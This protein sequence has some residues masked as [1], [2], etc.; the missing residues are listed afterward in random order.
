MAIDTLP[1]P[2]HAGVPGPDLGF[3]LVV[4]ANRAPYA[5]SEGPHGTTWSRPAGGLTAALDPL[6]QRSGGLWYALGTDGDQELSVPPEHPAYRVVVVGTDAATYR[7]HYNGYANSGLWP[8]FHNLVERAHFRRR[9]FHA[10]REAN[11]LMADRIAQGAAPDDVI[12]VHDYQLLLVP[13]ML[14]ERGLRQPLAHFLHIPW[15]PISVLRLCPERRQ[16]LQG[17]LASDWLGFQT[18]ESVDSFANAAR[19]ELGARILRGPGGVTVAGGGRTTRLQAL[20]I[21]IDAAQVARV[22]LSEETEQRM[23]R[24]RERL[25]LGPNIRMLLGVDRL[26]YTKGIPGRLEALEWILRHEPQMR[27]RIVLVQVAAPTRTEIEDYRRLAEHVRFKV[28]EI[29]GRYGTG[30]WQPIRLIEHNLRPSILVALY[31]LADV[32]VVSSLYDGLNLVAK[33]Y[34]AARVDGDGAL[35]L[36]ETAGAY[37]ELRAAFPLSPLMPE[38]M[39]EGILRALRAPEAERRERMRELQDAVRHNT[40][41]TWLSGAVTGI[42][43][44]RPDRF[45]TPR[46]D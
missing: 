30:D 10:Y 29:N 36:S 14:R 18:E 1:D 42:R 28:Q 38:R 17:L 8:L 20:P 11:R 2:V 26:D 25:R 40:I 22:A 37:N 46:S 44:S 16:I 6:M 9:D 32:A 19:R 34:V 45:S 39:A 35:C 21:S 13:G 31:R 33:E 15:P 3:R 24:L 43:R 7:A 41:D 5:R 27:G 23:A 12:W 4:A